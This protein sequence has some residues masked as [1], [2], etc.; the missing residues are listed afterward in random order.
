[1][2]YIY[3]YT[4]TCVYISNDWFRHPCYRLCVMLRIYFRSRL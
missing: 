4:H 2:I 3:I 1:M